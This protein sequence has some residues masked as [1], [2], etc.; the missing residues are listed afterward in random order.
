M[1]LNF[2]Y[3]PQTFLIAIYLPAQMLSLLVVIIWSWEYENIISIGSLHG[4]FKTRETI[5]GTHS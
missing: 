4:L 3:I 5:Y 1:V 2:G